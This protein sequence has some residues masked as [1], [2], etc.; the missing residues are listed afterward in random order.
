MTLVANPGFPVKSHSFEWLFYWL[1]LLALG[2]CST[3]E[4][5]VKLG[6]ATMGTTW[7][8]VYV[9]PGTPPSPEV[10][11]AGISEVLAAVNARMST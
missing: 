1:M 3:E 6:G 4:T 2:G 10:I 5:P 9:E 11:H 7:S 8:V